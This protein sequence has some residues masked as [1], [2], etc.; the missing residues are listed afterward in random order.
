MIEIRQEEPKDYGAV[1]NVV[2]AAF[3][4]ADHADGNEAD[5]VNALRKGKS[6]IPELSLVAEE[7]GDITG[8]ILF[9][10]ARVGKETVLALAPLSVAPAWQ[11]QGIGTALVR[12]GHKRAKALGYDCIVV[13][14]SETYYPR[15]GYVPAATFGIHPPF[16]VPSKNF[17]VC[18]IGNA[19]PAP[20]G[21]MTYAKEFGIE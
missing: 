18:P 19:A 12:E 17:M 15:F 4:S 9:T 11:R 7:E 16:D 21:I 13:L 1:Y 2:K 3:E 6:F 5:L 20:R 14:G 8:H 10:K